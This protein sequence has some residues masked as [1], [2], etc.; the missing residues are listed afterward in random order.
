MF[1]EDYQMEFMHQ[2]HEMFDVLRKDYL[3]GEMV[4]NFADFM[5]D[6]C[7]FVSYFAINSF[8]KTGKAALTFNVI[9]LKVYMRS[10]VYCGGHV[11]FA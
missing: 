2:Y 11:I 5:T 6:E 3:A 1:T 7:K 9:L 8:Q 4:W 10:I